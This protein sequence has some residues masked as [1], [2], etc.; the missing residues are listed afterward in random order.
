MKIKLGFFFGENA[1]YQAEGVQK[2]V[3]IFFWLNRLNRSGTTL[4]SGCFYRKIWYEGPLPDI[5]RTSRRC[6]SR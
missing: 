1:D 2:S 4:F 5:V 6:L 3:H